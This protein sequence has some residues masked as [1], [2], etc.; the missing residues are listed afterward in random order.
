MGLLP[1]ATINA[2]TINGAYAMEIA[3]RTG[4]ITKGKVANLIL[5]NPIESYAYLHYSF[6]E[7]CIFKTMLKGKWY[8]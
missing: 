2:S 8:N 4:S 1:E 3:D 5:T 7:N 6:G